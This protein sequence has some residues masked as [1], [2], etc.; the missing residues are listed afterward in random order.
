[1]RKMTDRETFNAIVLY[2][3]TAGMIFPTTLYLISQQRYW[4]IGLLI[5]IALFALRRFYVLHRRLVKAVS[6]S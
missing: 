3:L 4:M 6:L 2:A 5:A 1:M